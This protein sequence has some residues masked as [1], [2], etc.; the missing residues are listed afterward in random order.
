MEVT[1]NTWSENEALNLS[2]R[3]AQILRGQLMQS[4]F[5]AANQ[6]EW[7]NTVPKDVERIPAAALRS[8]ILYALAVNRCSSEEIIET[9]QTHPALAYL[10]GSRIL[11]WQSVHE[12]RKR[13]AAAL[14][15]ALAEVLSRALPAASYNAC[16]IEA[17]ER[18]VRAMRADSILLD[19]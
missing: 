14:Q 9:A 19:L 17:R 4:V 7:H 16:W 6:G 10:R 3:S 13:N 12:F 5:N 1:A 2:G 18:L 8:L 15:R 11:D